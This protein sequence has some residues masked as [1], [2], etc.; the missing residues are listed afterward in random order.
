[1]TRFT[2]E[3]WIS[4][5]EWFIEHATDGTANALWLRNKSKGK[6]WGGYLVDHIEY[7]KTNS[8]W[9]S[10]VSTIRE[11]LDSKRSLL[12]ETMHYKTQ[13]EGE[14]AALYR[15]YQ[16]SK[17]KLN[18]PFASFNCSWCPS[19]EPFGDPEFVGERNCD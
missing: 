15:N 17:I 6:G 16:M 1:V 5:R 9:Q 10:V 14:P 7:L 4:L 18:G 2:N 12:E 13:R 8:T 11:D 3:Q 19:L